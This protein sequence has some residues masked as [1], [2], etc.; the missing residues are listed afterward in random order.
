MYCR[1]FH[2]IQLPFVL[3]ALPRSDSRYRFGPVIHYA[4]Q[5]CALS[6]P[7]PGMVPFGYLSLP[8]ER[9]IVRAPEPH[10]LQAWELP[11]TIDDSQGWLLPKKA[12]LRQLH[13]KRT[14]HD[15]FREKQC[16]Q[17]PN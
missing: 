8:E 16:P 5:R 4:R 7:P 2:R 14:T 3:R 9:G 11:Y 12:V 1:R 13:W 10:I 6:R 15:P 17:R